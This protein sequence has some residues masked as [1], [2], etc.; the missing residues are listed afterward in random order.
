MTGQRREEVASLTW[1][2]LNRTEL[3]W[4][5]PGHRAKNGEPN[6]IPLN[7]LAVGVLDGIVD[8][9][10]WL[11]R[12]KIFPTSSGGGFTAYHKGKEKIDR[13]IAADGGIPL[14]PGDCTTSVEHL[15]RDFNGWAANSTG[16]R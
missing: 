4:T 1:D 2:E 6:R 14:H 15:R 11:V 9:E 5:L 7:T 13:L 12:G 10:K 8:S 16:W 3:M